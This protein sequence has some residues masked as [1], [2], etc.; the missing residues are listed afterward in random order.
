ML[1]SRS[2]GLFAL[3]LALIVFGIAA[4]IGSFG[5]AF[6][7]AVG[8]LILVY[9]GLAGRQWPSERIKGQRVR[10]AWGLDKPKMG[11]IV[12]YIGKEGSRP[13]AEVRLD[14]FPQGLPISVPLGALIFVSWRGRLQH[15][16]PRRFHLPV[17]S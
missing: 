14:E 16:L 4:Y 12:R 2:E 6:A 11:T 8:V 7:I 10:V 3:A 17:D 1:P 15:F 5:P 9:L 13:I